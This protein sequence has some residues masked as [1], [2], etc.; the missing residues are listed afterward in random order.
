MQ[1]IS[2]PDPADSNY[3]LYKSYSNNQ[4]TFGTLN[5]KYLPPLSWISISLFNIERAINL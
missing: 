3:V 5:L 1:Y 4:G 2:Y